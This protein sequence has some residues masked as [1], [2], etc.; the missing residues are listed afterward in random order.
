LTDL[1]F[2]CEKSTILQK[3]QLVRLGFD[4]QLYFQE[5]IYRTP[6]AL[7]IFYRNEL[8]L[9][10]KRLLYIEKKGDFLSKVPSG[11]GDEAP[12]EHLVALFKLIHQ[13][14][15]PHNQPLPRI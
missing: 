13:I 1:N 3:Q 6:S 4:Q 15:S 12:I 5:G 2:L 9:R 14:K 10:E 7:P 11:G 8:I